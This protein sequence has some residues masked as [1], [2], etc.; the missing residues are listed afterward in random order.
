MAEPSLKEKLINKIKETDDLSVLEEVANLFELREPETVYRT[1]EKQK[2]DI[3]NARMQVKNQQTLTDEQA[4]KEA[5]EWL[6]E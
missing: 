5:D 1:N 4:N 2:E 3:E 6:D